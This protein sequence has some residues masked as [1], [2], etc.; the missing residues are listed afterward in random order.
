MKK[1]RKGEAQP[2]GLVS[3]NLAQPHLSPWPS[4]V[5]HGVAEATSPSPLLL[6]EKQKEKGLYL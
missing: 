5:A 2:L 1:K 6:L 4:L 3:G